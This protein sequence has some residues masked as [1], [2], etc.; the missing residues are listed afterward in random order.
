M[1]SGLFARLRSLW[2]G[3]HQ[4]RAFE[5]QMSDEFRVHQEL[6]ARDLARQGLP[7]DEAAR[8]ARLEFGSVELYKDQGRRSRG[9]RHVDALRFSLLDFRLG[10]RMLVKYPGLTFV[11]GFAMAFAIWVG[12]GTFEFLSQVVNPALPF[13]DGDRIVALRNRDIEL[14]GSEARSLYDFAIWRR[15]LRSVEE[16]GAWRPLDRNLIIGEGPGEPVALAEM[17]ASAFRITRIPARLG[18]TLVDTDEQPG[19]PPVVLIGHDLWQTR[20]GGDSAVVGRT[21]RLGAVL[22]TIVGVMP[23]GFGFPVAHDMWVPFRLDPS[24][25]PPREGPSISIF[26][27]LAPG[28]TLTT[29]RAELLALGQRAAADSPETHE[30][31]RA[32][33]YPYAKSF[34]NIEGWASLGVMSSNLL[35]VLLLMLICANIALLMFARAATRETELAVRTA[36]GASRSRIITQ[37]F[38]ESLVLGGVAAVVG[39]AAASVGLEWAFNTVILELLD[40]ARLPFWF[41]SHLSGSTVVYA[42]GLAVLAA[43][44]SGVLPALR[45]TRGVGAQLKASSAGGGG[46][47]F[48]GVWTFVIV[49][50]VA[51]TTV[52]PVIAFEVRRDSARLQRYDLGIP[53]E[54]YLSARV[55]MDRESPLAPDDTSLATFV[56]RWTKSFDAL[57]R[58]LES[59]PGVSGVTYTNLLPLSY[60]GWNQIEVDEGAIEPRDARGHRVSVA[61]IDPDYFEVLAAPILDGRR[62][63]S[64]DLATEAR[65]V[66]VN[67]PFVTQV[68]GGKNPI[69]RRIRFIAGESSRGEIPGDEAPWYEI[70]GLVRDLGTVNGYGRAGIY[71][72]VARERAYPTHLV[73]R[74]TGDAAAFVPRLRTLATAVDPTIRLYNAVPLNAVSDTEVKFYSFWFRLTLAVSG[75]ALLLSLAGIYAVMAFTVSRRTREIGIRLALGSDPRRIA[76]AIFRRPLTQ[77]AMGVLFGAAFIALLFGLGRG[78]VPTAMQLGRIGLYA[79]VMLAVCLLACLVPTRRAL[80]VQPTEALRAEG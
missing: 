43:V 58:R 65:T 28:A 57:E 80:R 23:K 17:S 60:H 30:H 44:V 18:R 29:A 71:H 69:G 78:S 10:F 37:L 1:I 67:Q 31:L 7:P 66:I 24:Q 70:V 16:L 40:G 59:E 12:A 68:L 27:R 63:H 22:T 76:L 53:A 6:R 14:G 52:F 39:L 74:L 41:H 50:Q 56:A 55:V 47:R 38:A 33:L 2:H 26:G 36:L 51:V 20:F 54:R 49:A 64:G 15:S 25:Y 79:L 32:Q 75:V 45:V 72:P 21:V 3:V 34:L 8:R 4:R 61:L 35:L 48:G 42:L 11:G 19:A 5:R 62:F 13:R 9:L 46:L 77:V 73:M